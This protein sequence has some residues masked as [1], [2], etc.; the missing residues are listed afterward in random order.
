MTGNL[1]SSWY[2]AVVDHDG[3]IIAVVPWLQW[4]RIPTP[5]RPLS[6]YIITATDELHAFLKAKR[7]EYLF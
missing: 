4:S 6:G 7:G 1:K 3:D 5:E 2:V